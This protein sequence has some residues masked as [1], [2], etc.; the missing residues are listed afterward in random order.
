MNEHPLRPGAWIYWLAGLLAIG[1]VVP[2]AI[3]IVSAVKE[4]ASA[5]MHRIRVPGEARI[6]LEEAGE[7]TIY[8]ESR[9]A[10]GEDA[11]RPRSVEGLKI[12]LTHDGAEVTLHEVEINERYTIGGRRGYAL[13]R[14][15]VN[16]PCKVRLVGRFDRGKGPAGGTVTLAVGRLKSMR[17]VA[18]LLGGILAAVLGVVL[19]VVVVV[20]GLVKR[21]SAKS[22]RPGRPCPPPPPAV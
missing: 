1:G 22:P 19:C 13:W 8:H 9:G 4:F 5:P 7:Y 2:G 10:N 18:L 17:F 6:A 3:L 12:F 14:F 15:S 11:P 20:V 16:E 21:S